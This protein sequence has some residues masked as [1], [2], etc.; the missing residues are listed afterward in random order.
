MSKVFGGEQFNHVSIHTGTEAIQKTSELGADALAVGSHVAFGSGAYQPGTPSGDGLMAHELA[1]V[2]Q[3]QGSEPLLQRRSVAVA[4]TDTPQE[5]EAE[6]VASAV[7]ATLY[8]QESGNGEYAIPLKPVRPAITN[9][10]SIQRGNKPKKEDL[11]KPREE[12]KSWEP[13]EGDKIEEI[14]NIYKKILEQVLDNL[15]KGERFRHWSVEQVEE[16]DEMRGA[17]TDALGIT[18]DGLDITRDFRRNLVLYQ[19]CTSDADAQN[20]LLAEHDRL[21]PDQAPI[22]RRPVVTIIDWV[23][24]ATSHIPKPG[25]TKYGITVSRD[26]EETQEAAYAKSHEYIENANR[27][28]GELSTL[29]VQPGIRIDGEFVNKGELIQAI[30]G[31]NKGTREAGTLA[32][33]NIPENISSIAEQAMQDHLPT[34]NA[35]VQDLLC[36]I[37]IQAG[38]ATASGSGSAGRSD[39]RR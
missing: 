8:P 38:L 18:G 4:S 37:A 22:E 33:L 15:K 17:M 12:E 30:G 11:P 2:V 31:F 26:A 13:S 28:L 3:Q 14:Q 27:L 10:L 35:Q 5:R 39:M 1:H 6:Q 32:S 36:Q 23:R 9:N 25:T 21:H 20:K 19:F 34:R 7:V 16:S 29:V 24:R